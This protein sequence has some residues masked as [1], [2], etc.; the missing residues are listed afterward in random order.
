MCMLSSDSPVELITGYLNNAIDNACAHMAHYV[1]KPGVDFSR[2]PELKLAKDVLFLLMEKQGRA[3][4]AEIGDFYGHGRNTPAV[5]TIYK[6]RNKLL[7]EFFKDILEEFTGRILPMCR[8]FYGYMILAEDGT[9]L[10]YPANSKEVDEYICKEDGSKPYN[11]KHMDALYDVMTGIFVGVSTDGIRK[12]DEQEQGIKLFESIDILKAII[13]VDRG[14]ES[15][16]FMAHTI[17]KGFNFVLRVKDVDSNG[18]ASALNL[19]TSGEF[20]IEINLD[21]TNKQTEELKNISKDHPELLKII[22]GKKFDYLPDHSSKK[23]PAVM[24]HLHFRAVRIEVEPGVFALLFTNL[25]SEKFPPKVLK[26][27]YHL[28]WKVE[29]AFRTVKHTLQLIYVTSKQSDLIEQEIYSKII[30]YNLIRMITLFAEALVSMQK[31]KHLHQFDMVAATGAVRDYLRG[32]ISAEDLLAYIA[33]QTVPIRP[34]RKYN[35]KMKP[36]SPQY[37]WYKGA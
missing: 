25:D 8:K 33:R 11:I 3:M 10:A 5:S 1:R 7:P 29:V 17:E 14:Y 13:T 22:N 28:R 19:P 9:D 31:K 34:G 4:T 21:L 18:I 30:Q 6:R 36:K 27:L 35:R 37:P 12:K 32:V 24:Y 16:N 15:F 26:E 2:D 23:D 20:D